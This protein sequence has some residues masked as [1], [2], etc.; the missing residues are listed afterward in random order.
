MQIVSIL[1]G[2]LAAY[3]VGVLFNWG[4]QLLS[5]AHRPGRSLDPWNDL[6]FSA[7]FGAILALPMTL[8]VLLIWYLLARR[9]K[10]VTY[11]DA[12][13]SGAAGTGLAFWAVGNPLPWLLVGLALGAAFGAAFWLT[14]FGRRRQVTLTLR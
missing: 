12:L 13:A 7:V 5:T 8:L 9:S 10:T 1:R 2:C 11:R 3:A 4:G 6:W 14:A